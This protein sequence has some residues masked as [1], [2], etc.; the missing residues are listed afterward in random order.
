MF[1]AVGRKN[2]KP[3][4]MERSSFGAEDISEIELVDIF[5]IL[6]WYKPFL[7]KLQVKGKSNKE[8]NCIK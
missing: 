3:E 6:R 1:G 8:N 4:T 2:T 7:F 5:L